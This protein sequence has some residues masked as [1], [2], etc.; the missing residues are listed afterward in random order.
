MCTADQLTRKFLV[1]LVFLLSFASGKAQYWTIGG[2]IGTANYLGEIGGS[3]EPKGFIS[4]LQWN[5][6]RPGFNAFVRY[7]VSRYF[8]VHGGLSY[9]WIQGADSL[10]QAPTRFTRNLSFRNQIIEA[11][12]RGELTI[13][14]WKVVKRGGRFRLNV[15]P[16]IYGGFGAFYH[17]PKT[18]YKGEWIALQPLKTEGIQY[19]KVQACFPI[20][21]G[22]KIS[23]GRHHVLGWDLGWRITRT[24]Y[25]DDLSTQYIDHSSNPDP[26]VGEIAM[27]A[28]EVNPN[29]ERFIGVD[30]FQPNSPRGN[31]DTKDSYLFS[32]F[33]Y[34]YTIGKGRRSF[35]KSRY[36]FGSSNK[37]KSMHKAFKTN[38]HR[39]HKKKRKLKFGKKH[40]HPHF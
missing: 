32:Y 4:D 1:A 2:G 24:D 12:V 31:P 8:A 17:N 9:G 34:G 19:N 14:D 7:E 40:L 18:N 23:V 29:D 25:L 22:V 20:G 30:S 10:S 6:T 13:Y 36:N 35:S 27:R 28:D 26:L 33:T 3:Y 11:A 5:M 38:K 16:Y 21:G 15:A 37:V 39:N